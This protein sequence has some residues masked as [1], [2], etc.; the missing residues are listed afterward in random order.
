MTCGEKKVWGKEYKYAQGKDK[1]SSCCPWEIWEHLFSWSMGSCRR[2]V[3]DRVERCLGIGSRKK[4][5]SRLW[6]L[7]VI[8]SAKTEEWLFCLFT[9]FSIESFWSTQ[10]KTNQQHLLLALWCSFPVYWLSGNSP[11]WIHFRPEVTC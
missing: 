6:N 8:Q 2:A 10:G 5:L 7:N 9:C 4:L 11:R 1:G 3:G